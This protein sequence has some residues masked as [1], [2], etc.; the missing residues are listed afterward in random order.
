GD[1]F[2]DAIVEVRKRPADRPHVVLE[3]LAP[4]DAGP[5]R[6]PE[7]DTLADHLVGQREVPTVPHLFVVPADQRFVLRRGHEDR[8]SVESSREQTLASLPDVSNE[9]VDVLLRAAVVDD[10]STKA[11]STVDRGA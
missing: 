11:K 10:A 9:K 3:V 4:Q 5:E 1:Q 7:G 2:L 6:A 8:P